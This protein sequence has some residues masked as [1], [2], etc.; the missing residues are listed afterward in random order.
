M[1][2][3]SEIHN[4]SPEEQEEVAHVQAVLKGQASTSAPTA[5]VPS[6]PTV[7][8]LDALQEQRRAQEEQRRSAEQA[9]IA[10]AKAQEAGVPDR[11]AKLNSAVEARKTSEMARRYAESFAGFA[12]NGDVFKAVGLFQGD[13]VVADN[14]LRFARENDGVTRIESDT[15]TH[16][17]SPTTRRSPTACEY[18]CGCMPS[19]IRSSPRLSTSR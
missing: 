3:M 6:A 1:T 8:T 10:E 19:R 16:W 17:S 15:A 12:V 4:L 5:P 2:P 13:R 18:V 9:L 11:A 14:L 7:P